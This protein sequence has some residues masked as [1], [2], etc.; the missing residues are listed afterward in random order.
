MGGGKRG[1]EGGKE[2]EGRDRMEW[3]GGEETGVTME[4]TGFQL[5]QQTTQRWGTT[6]PCPTADSH[7]GSVERIQG[8]QVNMDT[9]VTLQPSVFLK[10][11]F[12]VPNAQT[13]LFQN[14]F[15]NGEF[16]EG[17]SLRVWLG[18]YTIAWNR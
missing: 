3:D 2:G 7:G 14:R 11:K 5:E 6:K 15:Q 13:P 17:S 12:S 9:S 10:T 1:E 4:I 18:F 8:F 16:S